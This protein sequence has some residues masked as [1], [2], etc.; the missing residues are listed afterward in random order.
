MNFF[1][2]V[3][4]ANWVWLNILASWTQIFK[5]VDAGSDRKVLKYTVHHTQDTRCRN[6]QQWS[7][8]VSQLS[9]SNWNYQQQA[10]D[11]EV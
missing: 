4:K 10:V 6:V 11:G 8:M 1:F 7:N 9:S 3:I 5:E 2:F